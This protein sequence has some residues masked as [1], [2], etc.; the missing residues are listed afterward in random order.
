LLSTAVNRPPRWLFASLAALPVVALGALY[1]APLATLMARTGRWQAIATTARLP[2]IGAIWWFTLWQAALSAALTIAASLVPAYVLGRFRVRGRQL[3]LSA[4]TVAFIMPTVVVGAAFAALLPSS[5]TGTATAM[6]VA[7]VWLNLA[8][9]VRLQVAGWQL[10]PMDET[11]AARTLGA[12][13]W[14]IARWAV[15]PHLRAPV[16]TAA[17]MVFAFSFMSYGVARVLGGPGNPTVE[18]EIARRATAL[19]D[20]D[21]AA[22]LAIAQLLVMAAIAIVISRRTVAGTASEVRGSSER[23][24]GRRHRPLVWTTMAATWFVVLAP[25]AVLAVRSVRG[26]DGFTWSGWR[27]W[28]NGL[29]TTAARLGIDAGAALRV[30]LVNCVVATAAATCV[31]VAVALAVR[32]AVSRGRSRSG[33]V[34]RAAWL[35]PLATAPVAI[36]FGVLI[37][38]DQAPFDWRSSWLMVPITQALLAT[39]LVMAV[40]LPALLATPPGAYEAAATL[41]ASPTVGWWHIDARRVRGPALAGAGLAAAVSLGDF[42]AASVL[43]RTGDPTATVAVVSLLSRPGELAVRRGSALATALMVLTAVVVLLVERTAAVR[44]R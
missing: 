37:T 20:V 6:I 10:L 18:V 44:Q 26:A 33:R 19:G 42:G 35:A 22:V 14:R 5:W 13:P 21:G 4:L 11:A 9:A 41:G 36:G 7:H 3:L 32:V 31:G 43:S 28:S 16:T 39:P 30:S 34:L 24:P 27:W 1:A 2:G 40:C 29:P 15:W 12:S 25:M 17:G 38:F 23:A 8:V